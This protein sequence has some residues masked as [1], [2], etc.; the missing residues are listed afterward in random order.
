MWL[1]CKYLAKA[2]SE[3]QVQGKLYCSFFQYFNLNNI[4]VKLTSILKCKKSSI[5]T[6]YRLKASVKMGRTDSH[7][8]KHV[9]WISLVVQCRRSAC[10][11]RGHGFD[12]WSWKI[13]HV[14]RQQG[15]CATITEARALEP[16]LRNKR[17]L[18][19]VKKSSPSSPQLE[20][21]TCAATKIQHS[22]KKF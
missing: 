10:Q 4:W 13:S 22:Q 18:Y 2:I 15:P 8:L 20:K 14:P 16:M 17:S 12:L 9:A 3:I 7:Y 1:I 5:K 11:C 6:T 19:T 21:A